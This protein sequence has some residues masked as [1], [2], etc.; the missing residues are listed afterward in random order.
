MSRGQT[1]VAL[2]LAACRGGSG[3]EEASPGHLSCRSRDESECLFRLSKDWWGVVSAKEVG[4][5][6]RPDRGRV[7]A[8]GAMSLCSVGLCPSSDCASVWQHSSKSMALH[9]SWSSLSL[10]PSTSSTSSNSSAKLRGWNSFEERLILFSWWLENVVVFKVFICLSSG[11]CQE[12]VVLTHT[13]F[14]SSACP[15]R[16]IA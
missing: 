8:V 13:D 11:L 16:S 15:S 6:G 5:L 12:R 10:S 7:L 1:R 3:R 4:E 2:L 14:V 9:S